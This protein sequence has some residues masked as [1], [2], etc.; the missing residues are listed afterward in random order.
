MKIHEIYTSI[1]GEVN[2]WGQGIL[3]TFIRTSGCNLACEYCDTKQ[4]R[5]PNSGKEMSVGEIINTV[6]QIGCPKI[7][8]TGGEP[9]LQSEELAVLLVRL[10]DDKDIDFKV[11][12]ETNGSI[13]IIHTPQK[14]QRLN[15]I[16][17]YKLDCPKK[18]DK[19][20]FLYLRPIDYIKM[21]IS[22]TTGY[23]K[24]VVVMND[25]KKQGCIAQFV[26]S[27]THNSFPFNLTNKLIIDRH[28]DVI[29]NCQIHKYLK[30][31]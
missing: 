21:V 22:N 30:I 8:I 24:A 10:F 4:A 5:D 27:P 13:P 19:Q 26:F 7:T 11:S 6:K 17:D 9:L 3:S 28:W 14:W 23:E 12:I 25:L 2:H 20:N 31:K 29:V 15:W 1:D 16:V 18:M